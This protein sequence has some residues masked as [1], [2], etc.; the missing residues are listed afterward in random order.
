EALE[1][2]ESLTHAIDWSKLPIDRRKDHPEKTFR[3]AV[4]A[5]ATA[6]IASIDRAEATGGAAAKEPLVVT[7]SKAKMAATC[8]ALVTDSGEVPDELRIGKT[9]NPAEYWTAKIDRA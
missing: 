3:D 8:D 4:F 7:L 5:T 2:F 1:R 9:E 6:V